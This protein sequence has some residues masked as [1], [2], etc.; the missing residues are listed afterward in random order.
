MPRILSIDDSLTIRK[1][2]ESI[3]QTA[4][5]EVLLA[6]RGTTGLEL[7]RTAK[8]DLIL[9]DFVLP[10]LPSTE[11]CRQLLDDPA[12]ADIPIRLISTNGAAI[13]QL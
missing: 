1:M 11:L 12:T 7:A 8:P 10:D 2:V 5:H 3:L 13:R 6:D 9:L 4:G